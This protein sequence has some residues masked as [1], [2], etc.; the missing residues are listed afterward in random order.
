MLDFDDVIQAQARIAP[1]IAMTPLLSSPMLN[2]LLGAHV[3]VKAE[4]LQVTGS[5]KFRGALNT[6]LQLDREAKAR[7]V[8]AF[9]SGN[10]GQGVAAAA[11]L[12]GVAAT[13]ILPRTAPQVKVDNCRWWQANVVIYDPARESR[14]EIAQGYIGERGM[15]LIHPFDDERI[16]AGQGTTGL[17]MARQAVKQGFRPD[18]VVTAGSGGG[19][20]SGTFLALKHFFPAM[21]CMLVEPDGYE[22][23]ARSLAA[24][25]PVPNDREAVTVMDALI[26]RVPGAQPLAVLS[27]LRAGA[28]SVT[29]DEALNAVLAAFRY[30]RIVAEP[31]G[32]APLAAILAGKIDVS[33][34]NVLLVCSGGNVDPVL[35]SRILN[36]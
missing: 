32:V 33:G 8:V 24:G 28:V 3:C 27:A 16:I 31:A 23:I 7:G 2:E 18:L 13:I 36:R 19:L 21:E 22:K 5:F 17:E 20:A 26:G 35:L 9:S 4:C 1:Y 14:E 11:K 29:E 12:T 30:L 25:R 15:T 6:I 10:H 34:R